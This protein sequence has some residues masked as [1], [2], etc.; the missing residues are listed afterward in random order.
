MSLAWKTLDNLYKEGNLE[1]YITD[2]DKNQVLIRASSEGH[3]EVVK[4]LVEKCGA[5]VRANNDWAFRR[6][7]E[8]G[9]LDIVKYL[10]EKCGAV[11]LIPNPKYERYLIICERGEEKRRERAIKKIYF[12]WVQVCYDVKRSCGNRMMKR[13]YE[14]YCKIVF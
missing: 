4:Y 6:A 14:E 13:N 10:V 2:E 5:D 8:N 12:W 11:L 3:L 9:H 1:K 7:S